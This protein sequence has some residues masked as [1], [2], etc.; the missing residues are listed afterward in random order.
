M[1]ISQDN[2]A[3]INTEVTKRKSRI[4]CTISIYLNIEKQ[5]SYNK[6]TS[7]FLTCVELDVIFSLLNSGGTEMTVAVCFILILVPIQFFMAKLQRSR[8]GPHR[9]ENWVHCSYWCAFSQ[10]SFGSS[11]FL[12]VICIIIRNSL[13]FLR[14]WLVVMWMMLLQVR[15]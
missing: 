12:S 14:G 4:H 3:N 6:H 2:L 15:S 1:S 10:P 13:I 11:V 7:D 8:Y 5:K 9:T